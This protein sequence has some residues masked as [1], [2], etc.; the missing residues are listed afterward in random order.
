[1]LQELH[2]PVT[3]NVKAIEWI[4]ELSERVNTIRDDM[5]VKAEK[6]RRER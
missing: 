6:A 2:E 4:R 5:L 3:R 1:M